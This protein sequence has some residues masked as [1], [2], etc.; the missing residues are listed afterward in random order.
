[1]IGR[2]CAV[3]LFLSSLLLGDVVED[4]R[5]ALTHNDFRGA[6]SQLQAYQAKHGTDPS[7]L[8]GLSWMARAALDGRDYKQAYAYARQTHLKSGTLLKKRKLDAEPHLPIALGAAYEVEAQV[9]VAKG[10]R[11]KAVILLKSALQT[12]GNTSIGARL[13]KN[14]NSLTLVGKP[15]PPLKVSEHF[16]PA[17]VRLS[18]LKGS[19]VLL[20][21]WAHWC[22]ECKGESPIITQ[23]RSEFAPKGLVVIAPTQRYGYGARGEKISPRSELA[24]IQN[25]WQ[26]YYAG[27]QSVPVPVSKENFDTYGASTTPTLVLIDRAGRIAM[28]HPGAIPYGE[29]RSAIGKVVAN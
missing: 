23:L 18:E 10:E 27:L 11:A 7:Y 6:E 15:A 25:V 13:Q 29:L 1:M 5:V 19:P 20:F 2:V 8:E 17:P 28:Y 9:L 26:Q 24:Y 14:L 3:I 12:Y 22:V 21:F 16:G 4:V